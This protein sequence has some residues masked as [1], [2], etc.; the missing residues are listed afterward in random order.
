[1]ALPPDSSD[2]PQHPNGLSASCSHSFTHSHPSLL[3]IFNPVNQTLL[4]DDADPYAALTQR[5]RERER[6]REGGWQNGDKLWQREETEGECS[7]VIKDK[8]HQ[9]CIRQVTKL[10]KSVLLKYLTSKLTSFIHNMT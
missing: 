1:M 5:E 4:T 3:F 10:S 2:L 7:I 8:N 6:K 9:K